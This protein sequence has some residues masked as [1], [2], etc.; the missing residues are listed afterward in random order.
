M[1][2]RRHILLLLLLNM[3]M[4]R[5]SAPAQNLPDS[6]MVSRNSAPSLTEEAKPEP[7]G[8]KRRLY[9]GDVHGHTS[10]SDGTGSV[11]EYFEYARDKAKLDFA[12]VTDHDFGNKAPWRMPRDHWQF[13]QAQAN[14]YTVNGK[15]VAIVGYEWTSQPKYWS[16]FTNGVSERIFAGPPRYYNHKNV[17]FPSA[18]DYLF[19]SKETAYH[20]PGLLAAAVR[21]AG[22]L[23]H[24][25]HPSADPDCKDQFDYESCWSS[26]IANTEILADTQRYQGRT[27]QIMGEKVVQ[28]FL[29]RGGQTG[30]VGGSDTHDGRP[31]A[32]TAVQA[33]ALTR[34]AIFDALRNRHNYAVS[35]AR[36]ALD[37]TINGH[38]MGEN[39][40]IKGAPLIMA[41]VQ[42]TERLAA[43]EV[44][45]N[46]IV[47]HRVSPEQKK[48]IRFEWSDTTFSGDA[49]YYLRVTQADADMNGNPSLAWSSPIW[50]RTMPQE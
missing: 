26:V 16:G 19:S 11:A 39:M 21:K 8:G 34:E 44:I 13:L 36:I 37:F 17:Y 41:S 49:W 6:K 12:I 15:F 29:N 31:A 24:N 42:G 47:L 45:R 1:T 46:G 32:R 20:T 30:F 40:T 18:I 9:W 2:A 5:Y 35:Q 7:A 22:G 4:A 14:E 43:V 10:Y 3:L 38:G 50:V 23:I 25:N 48:E 27:Y 33:T 28:D